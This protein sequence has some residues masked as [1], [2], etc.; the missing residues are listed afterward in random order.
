MLCVLQDSLTAHQNW[1]VL[2]ILGTVMVALIGLLVWLVKWLC[3]RFSG[4]IDKCSSAVEVSA[5]TN[6]QMVAELRSLNTATT[7]LSDSLDDMP[8]RTADLLQRRKVQ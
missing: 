7:R 5:Q 8:Q 3:N 4:A 6:Q 1:T 2:G